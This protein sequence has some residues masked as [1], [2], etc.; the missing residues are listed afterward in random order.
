MISYYKYLATSKRYFGSFKKFIKDEKF[1]IEAW[2]NH[3][4]S[5]IDK[6]YTYNK[7]IIFYYE[8]FK[9]SPQEQLHRMFQLMGFDI[10]DEILNYAVEKSS[11]SNMQLL[12]TQTNTY[13]AKQFKNFQF[14]R[15]GE[16]EQKEDFI[17]SECIDIIKSNISK[18]E[19][20]LGKKFKID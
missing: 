19:I 6:G 13:Y 3:T 7:L 4:L 20:K 14:V 18:I 2:R 11:F 8:D 5:W 1:G 12:E 10:S 17:D 16:V 15:K 9:K